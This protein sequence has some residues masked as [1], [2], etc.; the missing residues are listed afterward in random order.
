MKI[1]LKGTIV[2]VKDVYPAFS[3][4]VRKGSL[5][6]SL[7][8]FS[9]FSSDPLCAIFGSI[10]QKVTSASVCVL[11]FHYHHHPVLQSLTPLL[12]PELSTLRIRIGEEGNK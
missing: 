11:S 1:K 7:P 5:N 4:W 2:D 9:W 12:G 3:F 10:F 8:R 6:P